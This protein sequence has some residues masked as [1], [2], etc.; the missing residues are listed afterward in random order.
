M[1]G[2]EAVAV[3]A[4]ALNTRI[5]FVLELA[6]R[7]HQYGTAAPRL[8]DAVA[9]AAF[10]IGLRAEVWSSPTAIILSFADQAQG[11]DSIAQVTQVIRLPPGDVNLARLCEVDAVADGV[12]DGSISIE[13]GARE[14]RR[15]SKPLTRMQKLGMVF[16][17]A[18]SVLG[19]AVLLHASLA[20]ALTASVLGAMIGA[21]VLGA[22]RFPRLA[23]A[24]EAVA[25][26]LAATGA[27]LVSAWIVPIRVNLVV[28]SALIVLVPGMML[29]AAVR[30]LSAQHLASGVSRLFGGLAS[31]LKLIFGVMVVFTATKAFGFKLP[32]PVAPPLPGWVQWPAL[33][34]GTFGFA[35]VF[36]AARRDWLLVALSA[37]LGYVVAREAGLQFGPGFG[38]FAGGLVLGALG[39]LYARFAHRPGAIVR[40]PGIILL[41]PGSV[42]YQTLAYLA[43]RN[44]HSGTETAILLVT[45][46]IALV[47]GLLFGDLL[48]APRRSL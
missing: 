18:L 4:T 39:N 1:S 44:V 42:G 19:F 20:D 23:L 9:S 6:R 45:L 28:L 27:S 37:M 3:T 48:V 33:V 17:F 15:M 24:S 2:G 11:D 31:M 12:I 21:V 14:L 34:L 5:T 43:Q 16:G 8:E 7:L 13:E 10:R 30:E 41:V 40:E 32:L 35:L 26:I 47:A 22:S 46:L 36:L 38:V 25:A 29:T